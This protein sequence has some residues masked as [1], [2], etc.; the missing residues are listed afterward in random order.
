MSCWGVIHR[1]H[2]KGI[3]HKWRHY[4]LWPVF[5]CYYAYEDG[6][7]IYGWPIRGEISFICPYSP[8]KELCDFENSLFVFIF[9]EENN[10]ILKFVLF[11]LIF[12]VH[13]ANMYS[14]IT[15][16]YCTMYIQVFAIHSTMEKCRWYNNPLDFKFT[17]ISLH[18]S[19]PI[20]EIQWNNCNLD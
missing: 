11:A 3:V 13:T 17:V 9:L 6:D 12:L 7:V 8:C 5:F 18:C 14:G 15:V 2:R 19:N 16:V 1:L 20:K 4:F 10:V